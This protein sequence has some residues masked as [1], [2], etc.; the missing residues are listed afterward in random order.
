MEQYAHARVSLMW[1]N[2]ARQC[3]RVRGAPNFV[4]PMRAHA[5]IKGQ[6]ER[7][8]VIESYLL[9]GGVHALGSIMGMSRIWRLAGATRG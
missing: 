5:F 7:E 2:F 8:K 3:A 6:G 4:S 1:P 9:A